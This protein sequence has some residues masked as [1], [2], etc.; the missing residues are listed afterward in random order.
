MERVWWL[1]RSCWS[2][3]G[4]IRDP[5]NP[6]AGFEGPLRTGEREG[7]RRKRQEK[8]RKKGWK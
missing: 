8:E 1:Q 4:T 6:L 7:E 2:A 5:P 3:G